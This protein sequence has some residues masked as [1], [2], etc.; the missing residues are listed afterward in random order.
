MRVLA[1]VLFLAGLLVIASLSS[2][3]PP[4]G[5]KGG[6]GKG[7]QR[8]VVAEAFRRAASQIVLTFIAKG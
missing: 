3:Q 8:A 2:A 5:G 4:G 1:G 6:Q 7:G